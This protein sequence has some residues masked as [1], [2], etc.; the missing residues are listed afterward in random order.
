VSKRQCLHEDSGLEHI[1]LEAAR[2]AWKVWS[3]A[4]EV[5]M[6]QSRAER[7]REYVLI[8]IVLSLALTTL[9]EHCVLPPVVYALRTKQRMRSGSSL[10]TLLRHSIF[11][12][13]LMNEK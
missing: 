1:L 5:S 7:E 3:L 10:S 2:S 13:Y 12:L 11:I 8:D 9:S 6:C 4:V